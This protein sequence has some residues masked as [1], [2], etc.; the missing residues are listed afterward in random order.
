MSK[1]GTTIEPQFRLNDSSDDEIAEP[2]IITADVHKSDDFEPEKSIL[3][4][5]ETVS[6]PSTPKINEDLDKIG[7]VV[8]NIGATEERD[9]F[10]LDLGGK[11]IHALCDPGSQLC[12]LHS[13]IADK[14]KKNLKPHTS[15]S[16]GLFGE[17]IEILGVLPV[18]FAINDVAKT[19]EMRVM[20]CLAYDAII[21]K[22]FLK[23]FSIDIKNGL[24]LWRANNGPWSN[25]WTNE[26][27]PGTMIFAESAGLAEISQNQRDYINDLVSRELKSQTGKPLG[28]TNVLTHRVVLLP[29]VTP[30]KH[31]RRRMSPS[32]RKI[33]KE[34]VE[35]ML[36]EDIIEPSNGA[37]SSAPVIV[38]K[39]N[40][41][42]RFCVGFRDVNERIVKD[43]YQIPSIDDVLDD[44]RSAEYISTIDLTSSFHQIEIDED[45]RDIFGFFVEGMGFFRFKRMA[46]GGTNSPAELQRLVEILF[47]RS[48]PVRGYLDDI[49]IHTSTFKDHVYWLLQVLR[50]LVKANIHINLEKSRFCVTE[51]IY[52][53]YLLDNNGL[54]PDPEKIRPV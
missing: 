34:E 29:G 40:G 10:L 54:R 41:K 12:Y 2:I 39:K 24:S 47:P 28:K 16:V 51:V 52:L 11:K 26:A 44:L 48:W 35:R 37:W 33:A 13:K 42:Y 19:F 14:F 23:E 25:F 8:D 49:I 9:F 31:T 6:K 46:F 7:V 4:Q 17:A 21:G 30:V 32:I 45:C 27:R 5:V 15:L 38:R 3:Q 50:T 20:P 36:R 1:H 22:N 18:T 53:G 43:R